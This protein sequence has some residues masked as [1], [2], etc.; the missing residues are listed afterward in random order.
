MFLQVVGSTGKVEASNDEASFFRFMIA[1]GLVSRPLAKIEPFSSNDG[2]A[3]FVGS[4]KSGTA[5]RASS[6]ES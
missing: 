1:A 5:A 3:P 6:G 4:V 2:K